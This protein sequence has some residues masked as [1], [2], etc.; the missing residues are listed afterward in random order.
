MKFL[1]K[2][3]FLLLALAITV[4][5]FVG[6]GKND[7]GGGVGENSPTATDNIVEILYEGWNNAPIANSYDN[8]PYK[9]YIDGTY[10]FDYRVSL[11][12]SFNDEVSKRYA[13]TK[14]RFP[15]I[16]VWRNTG[17]TYTLMKSLYNQGF[18][19][20]DY[21]PYLDMSPYFKNVFETIP[22][23]KAKLS[24]NGK[25]VALVRKAPDQIWM[26]QIRKD[27]IN[28]YA[29]GKMPETLDEL[30]VM[31]ENVKKSNA[32]LPVEDHKYLFTSSGQ[33]E[34]LG[35]LS[36]FIYMFT[37]HGDWYFDEEG[38]V[39]HPIIDGDYKKL[40]DFVK[41]IYDNGYVDPN[42]LL[43][44]WNQ[45]KTLLYK[46]KIGIDW[47][48][49]VLASEH[50]FYN[51]NN[52]DFANIWTN[53]PM[54]TDTAGV[55]RKGV[56][57]NSLGIYFTINKDLVYNE[58]KFASVMKFLSDMM[59][60][61]ESSSVSVEESLYMKI[62]WGLDIDNY[63]IG[64]GKEMEYIMKDG[65]NTG[66][67]AFYQQKNAEN[68]AKY[69]NGATWDYG[70]PMAWDNDKVVEYLG[71]QNYGQS[72]YDYIDM[73]NGA[74]EYYSDE[75]FANVNYAEILNYNAKTQG[76][77]NDLANEFSVTYVLG[78]NDKTY[79]QFVQEWLKYGGNTV[80][81]IAE[82]QF[83]AAGFIK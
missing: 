71:A 12:G 55:T 31:A 18:F 61:D 48:P 14:S 6:C 62:R 75:R 40:L 53:M 34:S 82:S 5:G 59:Y 78:T 63:T 68:H 80:K 36:N 81:T 56:A 23:A 69:T 39:S 73:Y 79:E 57:K 58:K 1:K 65:E 15:D 76:T 27:W 83:E 4:G 42:F 13:S 17:E 11:T 43:Q 51:G 54:P 72:A 9:K 64:E 19:I 22:A 47:Y 20:E 41:T 16:V 50:V 8:N 70:V 7:N 49:P 10:G 3:L 32:G 66:F 77:L 21:T 29:G 28:E 44:D 38:N 35:T 30:L 24:E 25:I 2:S 74:I 33:R 60:P 52:E 67:I 45:K 37:E 26:H 46:D